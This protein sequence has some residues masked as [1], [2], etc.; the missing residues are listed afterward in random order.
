MPILEDIR[1]FV[2]LIPAELKENRGLFEFSFVVAERKDFLARQK[3]E[4]Q[5]KFRIDEN[6]MIIKFTE[7]LKESGSGI[8]STE[9]SPGFGFKKETYKLGAGG[10]EGT[11]EEQSNFFVKKYDYRFDFKN[12][13]SKIEEKC[14]S[15]G[16]KFTYQ[17]TPIGF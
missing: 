15:A 17:I 12:I 11:I 5:A 9:M 10:R 3:L 14:L 2:N 8:S 13:R 4:Y 16:Y 6:Q 1:Q 7:L